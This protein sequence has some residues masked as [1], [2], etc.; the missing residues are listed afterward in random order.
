MLRYN[1][2]SRLFKYTTEEKKRYK[3]Y[4]R[5]KMWVVAGMSL[6]STATLVQQVSA[7]E[8][9]LTST[10][11][12]NDVKEETT[13]PVVNINE[14]KES[15]PASQTSASVVAEKE[16]ADGS[17]EQT[18]TD[19]PQMTSE[20]TQDIGESDA[21][22]KVDQDQAEVVSQGE[23]TAK[24]TETSNG[25]DAPKDQDEGAKGQVATVDK[26][27]STPTEKD[28]P[29]EVVKDDQVGEQISDNKIQATAKEENVVDKVNKDVTETKTATSVV[30]SEQKQADE[31]AKVQGQVNGL[32]T[33]ANI[34]FLERE[35]DLTPL[36]RTARSVAT[37]KLETSLLATTAS[38]EPKAADVTDGR[39]VSLTSL[40]QG[41]SSGSLSEPKVLEDGSKVYVYD[42]QGNANRSGW[43]QGKL[44]M[45]VSYTGKKGDKFSLVLSPLK[46]YP[47]YY[48]SSS[49]PVNYMQPTGNPVKKLEKD[50]SWTMTWTIED[51]PD[52]VTVTRTQIIPAVNFFNHGHAA[53]SGSDEYLP[54]KRGAGSDIKKY[55]G[56]E[57]YEISFLINGEAAPANT[58]SEIV[59]KLGEEVIPNINI[60]SIGPVENSK[61]LRTVDEN[62]LYIVTVDSDKYAGNGILRLSIPVPEHF[63]LDEQ[64][65]KDYIKKSAYEGS[66]G[67]GLF[68]VTQPQGEGTPIV[69][70]YL[71][72]SSMASLSKVPF[73]GRYT[74]E[75]TTGESGQ[76]SGWYDVG[77]GEKHYF[78]QTNI[79]TGEALDASRAVK[80]LKSFAEKVLPRDGAKV[81][82]DFAIGLQFPSFNQRNDGISEYESGRHF[83][84]PASSYLRGYNNL[85][86]TEQQTANVPIL[87]NGAPYAPVLY[88]VGLKGNGL[89]SFTP[90]Y[91]F[92]FPA[93]VT[94]TGIVMPLNNVSGDYADF[95]SYNPAQTGYTVVV[96][97]ADG[98]KITQRLQAGES[99]NPTT[100]V[101][102]HFGKFSNGEKLAEGVKISAYDVTP[103]VPYYANAIMERSYDSAYYDGFHDIN[104]GYINIL[105][106]LN[107]LAQY[108]KDNV[109]T[110]N[111]SVTSKNRK[112]SIQLDLRPF[113]AEDKILNLP[114]RTVLPSSAGSGNNQSVYNLGTGLMLYLEAGGSISKPTSVYKPGVNLDAGGILEGKPNNT[115]TDLSGGYWLEQPKT[116]YKKVKDPIVYFTVP[117]QM[118][119]TKLV[120]SN[121]LYAVRS[122][123]GEVPEPKVSR[124]YNSDNQEVIILDWTGTG[125]ELGPTDR[126]EIYVR[127]RSDALN[128]F[129]TNRTTETLY[130]YEDKAN[131]KT[132]DL[133]TAAELQAMGVSTEG[134][135]AY[136]PN[137]YSDRNTSW[138][139]VGGD[140][141]NSDL[142]DS[143]KTKIVFN[144]G[145]SADTIPLLSGTNSG[146]LR[147][148]AP[149]E[150]RPVPLIKGTADVGLS[151]S[152][153]SYPAQ[154]FIDV[155]GKKTGLQTL[156]MGMVNNTAD[157]LKGVISVMNLPQAGVVDGNNP[158]ATQ[159]FTLNVSGPG[160]LA[161]DPT[162]NHVNDAHTMY[163]STQLA[164]LSADGTTLTFEDG[165][166]W[167]RGQALPSQL[168]TAD[169]VTDWSTVKSLVLYVPALSKS[170]KIVYR[171]S[172]YSPTSE[173][174]MSK[175]VTLRQV[176]GYENQLSLVAGAVTDT[177]A[178]YATLKIVDQDGNQIN[179]YKD[180]QGKAVL[181]QDTG[182]YTI[183]NGDLFGEAGKA[184]KLDPPETITGY[185][186]TQ[187]R[188]SPST[189][190]QADG[191][192]VVTRV[193]QVD[194]ARLLEGSLRGTE[195]ATATGD[196]QANTG[197]N[198]QEDPTG[199]SAISFSVTDAQLARKGYHYTITVVDRMGKLLTDK[200]GRSEYGTLAEA[201][202]AQGT[203]DSTS[204][205]SGATQ[206][207]IVN[208]VGD[209]Q[210][211]VIIGQND[212]ANEIPATVAEAENISPFYNDGVSGG[213]MFYGADGRPV[214]SDATTLANGSLA[215]RRQNYRYTVTAP[216][217]KEYS[218]LDAALAAKLTF[219]NTENT[220]NTDTDIQV[221]EI[222]YV[223]D[224]QTLRVTVIDDQ[225]TKTDAGYTPVT[226]VDKQELGSGLSNSEVS[227]STKSDY[228]NI[229]ERYKAAG[230]VVVSQ[231]PVP[232]NYDNDPTVDQILVVHLRH[233]T[234]D[235]AGSSVTLTEKINYLYAS[236][237]H[238]GD[239]AAPM[240]TSQPITFTSVDT[241][242]KVTKEVINTVWSSPQTFVEVQSPTVSGYTPDKAKIESINATHETPESDLSFTVYYAPEQQVLNY[243]VIDDTENKELVPVTL[244]GTG[245]S[246]S[247]VPLSIYQRYQKI[248]DD[249]KKQGYIIESMSEIPDKYDSDSSVDQFVVIHLSH[250]RLEENGETKTIKQMIR[251]VYGNGPKQGE[252]AAR[253]YTKDY[254]F[255][256]R[257][258]LDAVTKA[259]LTT[260]WSDPQTTLEVT[261]PTVAGYVADKTSVGSQSLTHESTDL[262]DV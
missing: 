31:P 147:I 260:V 208:Y 203:F 246:E 28:A 214:L 99:Y 43:Y 171:F 126:V 51:A 188:F 48:G 94:T 16:Q 92:D 164:T 4:K 253:T 138:V 190:L 47:Y 53:T 240:Y 121:R 212:P 234:E 146:Y 202:A 178:T 88:S 13:Q 250:D 103:D 144:D 58:R 73:V 154:D 211:A 227:A 209:F 79:D 149:V 20:Q 194:K 69:V 165:S 229:I 6:F 216:D 235:K 245:E 251:Y 62:Y 111:M 179:G 113:Q 242:D 140:F 93:E 197:S 67:E 55:H 247:D 159:D 97:G 183:E 180:V 189:L 133:Y 182:E 65:T 23:V 243:Q 56:G 32:H 129:D 228:E 112:R 201:L 213:T 127:V 2:N 39:S 3:L 254:V 132:L 181:D 249:Y 45:T 177:Y 9:P 29:A 70:D 8:A 152:G 131:N 134:L 233:D 17:S 157:P 102:D 237:I 123:Q 60:K 207:F 15:D 41:D 232:D 42:A 46:N 100:G 221:Y 185:K 122:A 204:D 107:T 145:T 205:I 224:L 155:N 148:I 256:S 85:P 22:S 187:N 142:S 252:E 34:D 37:N 76:V 35:K 91:H 61:V 153:L 105:G 108:G 162:N 26:Q 119:A 86:T 125:F 239:V 217:G 83:F 109:Y 215:F 220:G 151:S 77:D 10:T 5:K 19:K 255:T 66:Y 141:S 89:T 44:G 118:E 30:S 36:K 84:G 192:T 210:K 18:A 49:N 225:G 80:N 166:T 143:S 200:E 222:K 63:L 68:S 7:D 96:T 120:Y 98:S 74:S 1:A 206:N 33:K 64:A 14:T 114:I 231:D 139:Q 199:V 116:V 78:G 191:S 115:A 72:V 82:E 230:Y 184:L 169:Q 59:Y 87:E 173:H 150:V 262:N 27:E 136:A 241:I 24:E 195:L 57:S 106:Y 168:K 172:A 223:E 218:S 196:P 135:R 244:L 258:T 261:S 226:L 40:T 117:D 167:S 176:G 170:N 90:T 54:Y 160:S 38:V 257:N 174:N 186:F 52:N 81:Y 50:G 137:F 175:K 198:F 95:R 163:Y 25:Q 158:N 238:K 156:Q 128:G 101:I 104:T 21:V 248:A 219:D 193:Y 124:K 236:G 12:Q 259:V 11:A 130:A 161:I 71:R 110:T 75:Q